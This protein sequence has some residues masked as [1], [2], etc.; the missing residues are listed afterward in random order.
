V[1]ITLFDVYSYGII[2]Q[3]KILKENYHSPLWSWVFEGKQS[4]SNPDEIEVP[5]YRIIQKSLEVAGILIILYLCGML[6]AAGL[7]LSHYLLAYDLLFYLVLDPAFIFDKL[8]NAVNPYWLQNWY[9]IGY[10]IL[11]PYNGIYF[12]TSG[13]IG[14]LIVSFSCYLPLKK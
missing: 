4:I 3:Q 10:F 2:Y 14:L 5:R 11:K 12:F 1:L 8:H 6:P 13:V 9:Q 7:V